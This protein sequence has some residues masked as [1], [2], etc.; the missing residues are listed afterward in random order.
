MTAL[1]EFDRLEAAGLWRPGA[2]V[3][4]RDVIVS[5]GDATLAIYDMTETP[6][7]HWSLPAVERRNPGTRPALFS[8]G[9]D[10]AETLE[11]EDDLMIDAL[12][13]I[14]RALARSGPHR[15]RVRN[16]ALAAALAGLLALSVLWLPG[17]LHRQALAVA[18]PALRAD[19]GLRLVNALGDLAGP[20]CASATARAPLDALARRTLG[21]NGGRIVV[22]PA[23]L[24]GGLPLPG[25]I[26]AIGRDTVEDH[27]GPEVAAGHVLAAMV[28]ADM[29]DPI[30]PI[31]EAGGPWTALTLLTRGEVPERALVRHA[32]RLVTG[33]LP[34]VPPD[35]LL[36]RF[37]AAGLSIRPYAAARDGTG[38]GDLVPDPAGPVRSPEQTPIMSDGAWVALQ[39]ICD[40][41]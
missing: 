10:S 2:G 11:I 24:P 41:Q 8:P 31:L 5:L 38:D 22:L 33:P 30:A 19:T 29:V 14:G 40:G 16:A 26:V 13:R 27:E 36:A 23:A 3:Q 4:R 20:P 34:D 17:A 39:A 12:E 6:L 15:G 28:R 35:A 18:P 25:R 32:E 1:R 9:P 7:S 37:A 21:P